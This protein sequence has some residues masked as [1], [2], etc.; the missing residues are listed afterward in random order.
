MVRRLERVDSACVALVHCNRDRG[1][2]VELSAARSLGLVG[3]RAARSKHVQKLSAEARC[4]REA[5]SR[6]NT[7]P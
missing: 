4:H 3:R 7:V 5:A 6:E 1:S 2:V